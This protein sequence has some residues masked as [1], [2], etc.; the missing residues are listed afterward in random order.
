MAGPHPG[1][2]VAVLPPASQLP[3]LGK[4]AAQRCA[5][6]PAHT[7]YLVSPTAYAIAPV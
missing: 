4:Q 2:A 3:A 7:C 6:L 5:P 1:K